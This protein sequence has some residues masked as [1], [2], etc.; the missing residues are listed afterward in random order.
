[1]M[2]VIPVVGKMVQSARAVRLLLHINSLF[3][4]PIVTGTN[5]TVTVHLTPVT[6]PSIPFHVVFPTV[7]VVDKTVVLG[8]GILVDILPV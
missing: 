7:A 4:V 1:M 5:K 3:F 8:V 6:S 2:L